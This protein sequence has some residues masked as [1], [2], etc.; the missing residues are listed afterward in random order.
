MAEGGERKEL[1]EVEGTYDYAHLDGKISVGRKPDL[2]TLAVMLEG[3]EFW[4]RCPGVYI[5]KG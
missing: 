5:A 2:F 3:A 4:S 1:E